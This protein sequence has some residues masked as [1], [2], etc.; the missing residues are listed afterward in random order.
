M[1]ELKL[2]YVAP[3]PTTANVNATPFTIEYAGV[4][5]NLLYANVTYIGGEKKH[6]FSVNWDGNVIES[7]D[8]K[9]YQFRYLSFNR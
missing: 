3:A 2:K 7:E 6:E 5:D 8:S 4:Y 1:R 9:N